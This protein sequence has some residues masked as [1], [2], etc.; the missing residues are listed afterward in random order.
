MFMLQINTGLSVQFQIHRNFHAI[1]IVNWAHRWIH[2]KNVPSGNFMSTEN[3]FPFT[4]V[5]LNMTI[6]YSCW[7]SIHQLKM[8]SFMYPM[9]LFYE[10]ERSLLAYT[11]ILVIFFVEIR[12]T[13]M[14]LMTKTFFWCTIWW[15]AFHNFKFLYG[16]I[17][18]IRL[19]RIF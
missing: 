8:C 13:S 11:R 4:Q 18:V 16:W 17:T 7:C 10:W 12:S 9:I 2:R 14:K 15:T 6:F 19:L 5:N 3:I 1:L